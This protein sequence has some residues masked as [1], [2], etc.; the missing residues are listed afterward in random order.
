MDSDL[1][2]PPRLITAM[3]NLWLGAAALVE[4]CRLSRGRERPR[5]R[6]GLALPSLVRPLLRHGSGDAN[7]QKLSSPALDGFTTLI[8]LIMLATGAI[9]FNVGL[10][11]VY[12]GC[13][14]EEVKGRPIYLI[15]PDRSQVD[16]EP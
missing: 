8:V 2:H 15:D 13:I 3:V 16:K 4:A 12:I 5:E 7:I 6:G 14:F 9:R 11:G 10:L 1:Q